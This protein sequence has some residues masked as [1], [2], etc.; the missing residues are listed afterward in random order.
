MTCPGRLIVGGALSVVLALGAA[1]C[2]GDDET[3]GPGAS[4]TT[5]RS[6]AG[7]ASSGPTEDESTAGSDPPESATPGVAPATGIELTQTVVALNAPAGWKE[8]DGLVD[9]ASGARGHG[10]D[11]IYLIDNPSLASPDATIDSLWQ[12]EVELNQKDKD[13]TYERLDDIDLA[14]TPASFV[15]SHRKGSD[16]E[17]YEVT[18]VRSGRVISLIFQ[19][20]KKTLAKDPQ[21]VESVLASVRWLD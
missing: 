16:N 5:A 20:D 3:D 18:A 11:L 10:T 13:T 17:G 8:G 4:P 6:D 2:G 14:G 12:A 19:L 15:H 1:A 9:Y 21:L 7:D